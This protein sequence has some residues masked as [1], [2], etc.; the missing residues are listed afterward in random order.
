MSYATTTDVIS[1][2]GAVWGPGAATVITRPNGDGTWACE[3]RRGSRFVSGA[4]RLTPG[5]ARAAT[6]DRLRA[7]AQEGASA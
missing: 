2:A 4:P 1:A 6:V 3:A 5:A 7:L